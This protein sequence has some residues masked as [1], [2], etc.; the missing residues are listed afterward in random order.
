MYAIIN[1]HP[2]VSQIYKD[3]LLLNRGDL[4]GAE[5]EGIETIMKNQLQDALDSVK[6]K[7]HVPGSGRT[8]FKGFWSGYSN[9]Y[10][11]EVVDTSV[12]VDVINSVGDALTTFPKNFNVHPKIRRLTEGRSRLLANKEAIDWALAE[13]LAFGSFLVEGIPVRLSGQDCRRGT[14]SQRHSYWYDIETRERYNRSTISRPNQA[15]YCVYNSLLSEAAVLGFDYGYSLAEPNMLIIWEAQFGD[16]A[17]GAQV[18]IDQFLASS[19][20]KWGRVSGLVMMLPHGQEGAG[21]EH[22]SARLERY[23]QLCAENNMQVAYCTTAA[24]HFHILAPS[25]SLEDPQATHP[26][27]AEGPPA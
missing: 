8:K 21:P 26:H 16:F 18:I 6:I 2:S 27:D 9:T 12:A 15:N 25:D 11:H 24:Q 7:P 3:L 5:V 23:L 22:S 14:F 10:S 13:L 17:N 1:K 4:D 20:E 19:E